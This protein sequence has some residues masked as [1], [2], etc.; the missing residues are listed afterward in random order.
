METL[1]QSLMPEGLLTGLDEDG[2]RDLFLY[3]RQSEPL[4]A[5]P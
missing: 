1:D 4:P 5:E 2:I 3:L